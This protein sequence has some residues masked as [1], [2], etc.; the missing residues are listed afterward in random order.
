MTTYR[1]PG[2][3]VE[4]VLSYPARMLMTGV[5][6]F[7]GL[8]AAADLSDCN[9]R[10]PEDRRFLRYAIDP[11]RQVSIVRPWDAMRLPARTHAPAA[12]MLL[13]DPSSENF[14]MHLRYG[15]AMPA[16]ESLAP[17][18]DGANTP[19]PFAEGLI[20]PKPQRFTVWPEFKRAY[21]DLERCGF[22]THAVRGFFE[23]AGDLC[24]VQVICFEATLTA[25]HFQQALTTVAAYHDYDLVCAPDLV[26]LALLPPAR[27]PIDLA[28]MQSALLDHCEETG[29]RMAIL[30]APQH[31][32]PAEVEA[33]RRLLAGDNGALYYPWVKT[34]TGPAVTGGCVPPCGHVAGVYNRCDRRT[35]VFKAPANEVVHGV[36]DL[37]RTLTDTEQAPL[38]TA[39]INCL[40]TFTRRGIRVWGARTLSTLDAWRYVNV[41]RVF[42][43]AGRWLE[44]TLQEVVFEPHTPRL[45][46]RVTRELTAYFTDLA[47]QGALLSGP[48]GASFYVKCD[49]ETNPPEVR[50]QGQ[51]V[52]EIGLAAAPPTEV[53]VIRIIHG[54]GGVR[55]EGALPAYA[56]AQADSALH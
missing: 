56:Q 37:A 16:A 44:Y 3:Y 32:A 13:S 5:P 42:L 34:T 6:V 25:A 50:D 24:Y 41:R 21:G 43:T 53:I 38:N 17:A 4:N 9:A 36:I 29:D 10:L 40:R 14:R 45:W 31:A 30:D 52:T 47:R 7:L 18:R 20:E 49:A 33:H 27:A 51:I 48:E 15:S 19:V 23:N 35:G 26:W 46:E 8:I 39:G 11:A 55:V 12:D 54:P 2:V 1:T 28:S 22:L